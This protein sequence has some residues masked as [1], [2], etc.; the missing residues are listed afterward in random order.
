MVKHDSFLFFFF[1]TI[2]INKLWAHNRIIFKG[3]DEPLNQNQ[4]QNQ[5]S[6][7]QLPEPNCFYFHNLVVELYKI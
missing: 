5:K 1:I 6:V 2:S 3:Q 4:S 7:T